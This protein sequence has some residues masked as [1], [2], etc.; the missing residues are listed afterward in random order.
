MSI[1]VTTIVGYRTSDCSQGRDILEAHIF[2]AIL[3]IFRGPSDHL[4]LLLVTASRRECSRKRVRLERAIS[5]KEPGH[6][7]GARRNLESVHPKGHY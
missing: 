7:S 4:V 2:L 6:G 1:E 5:L 3:F